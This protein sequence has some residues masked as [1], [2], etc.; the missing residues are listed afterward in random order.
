MKVE[1]KSSNIES[2]EFLD[3]NPTTQFGCLKGRFRNGGGYRYQH[4]PEEV[5]HAMR[6]AESHG[7][8]LASCIKGRYQFVKEPKN[9]LPTL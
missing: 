2:F 3:P 7:K 1:S 4:V 9:D 5:F 8:F 6:Q